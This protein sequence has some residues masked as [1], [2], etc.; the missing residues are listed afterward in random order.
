MKTAKTVIVMTLSPLC[1]TRLLMAYIDN[2]LRRFAGAE[3]ENRIV[4]NGENEEM[5]FRIHSET[6]LVQR[7]RPIRKRRPTALA[8]NNP[9]GSNYSF[10]PSSH[11]TDERTRFQ[12]LAYTSVVCVCV[13]HHRRH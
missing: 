10:L 5:Y 3:R 8:N 12:H 2:F 7:R 13:L 6:V 9:G 11:N 4:R 1:I